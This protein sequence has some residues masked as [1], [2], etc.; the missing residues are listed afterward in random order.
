MIKA[1]KGITRNGYLPK[2]DIQ[3]GVGPVPVKVPR[4]RDRQNRDLSEK[5][6]VYIGVD[7]VY[8]NVR[9]D[10]KQCILVIMG[11]TQDG[12]TYC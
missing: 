2:R 11:A 3:T 8:C 9:M 6:Y 7:G 4:S 12:E 5:H 10:D 1:D